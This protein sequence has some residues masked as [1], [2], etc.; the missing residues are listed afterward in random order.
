MMVAW[1]AFAAVCAILAGLGW[2]GWGRRSSWQKV[3]G[4]EVIPED[5]KAWELACREEF[6]ALVDGPFIQWLGHGSVR[7]DW[8]GSRLLVDPNRSRCVKVAPRW[9]DKPCLGP[10]EEVDAVL[11]THAHM[12][13]LDD[14]TLRNVKATRLLVPEKT[15]DFVSRSTR[16]RHLLERIQI[17]QSIAV[18]D[19]SIVPVK[20]RHGGWRYPW[21]KGYFSCGYIIR[22]GEDSLYVAGDTAWGDH[23]DEIGRVHYPR[24]AILPI[25]AYSPRFFL[26]ERHLN[27]EEA[28]EAAD[29]LGGEYVV[30][31][32][33]GTFR[34]SVEPMSEP[35]LRFSGGAQARGRKWLLPVGK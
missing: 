9:F 13:H 27:P 1:I 17:G 12:D 23:F 35:L 7:I 18:G 19:L 16:E 32:H 33:F 4:W 31:C 22:N 24:W 26:K 29:R 2:L 8:A 30:P 20:A 21:Q 15:E 5:Q 10:G 34:L 25:G 14:G 11:I 3:S 6:S 28:L